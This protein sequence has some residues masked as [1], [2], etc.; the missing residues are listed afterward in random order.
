MP[1]CFS[2][3]APAVAIVRS[4]ASATTVLRTV[5]SPLV[6]ADSSLTK[7]DSDF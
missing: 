2:A 5:K 3:A 6:S 1:G 4:T 7:G